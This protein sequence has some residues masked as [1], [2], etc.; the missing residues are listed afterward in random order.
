MKFAVVMV[1]TLMIVFVPTATTLA[2]DNQVNIPITANQA[3]NAVVH[4]V[5]PET[6]E[7]A[8]VAL[9]DVRTVAEYFW[10]GAPAK[11]NCITTTD[12]REIFPL[13]GKV[14]FRW[15]D[16]LIF[17]VDY[18]HFAY[19]MFLPVQKVEKMEM[20]DISIHI[21]T[22]LWDEA[23]GKKF[24]NK[25]FAQDIEALNVNYDVLILMCRSGKRSN[26]R[27]FDTTLFDKIYEIDQP[28]GENGLG[29]FQGTS[30]GDA[31]NGY[32]GYPGRNT[33][34]RHSRSVSWSDSGLPVHIGW[35]SE[36]IEGPETVE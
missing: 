27:A 29:G 3:F 7:D 12:G 20:I 10:V 15:G 11:V 21:P 4:Q 24:K 17:Q 22:H 26:T 35:T 32:R 18:G 8:S 2:D 36:Y 30:Y 5:D 28:N 13:D 16:F 14:A 23:A 34:R 31:Y 9:I 1:V 6:G 33:G 25:D 19:P